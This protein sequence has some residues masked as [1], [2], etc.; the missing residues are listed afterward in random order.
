MDRARMVVGHGCWFRVVGAIGEAE[1]VSWVFRVLD[2]MDMKGDGWVGEG[3]GLKNR[4]VGGRYGVGCFKV[5][6]V[7]LGWW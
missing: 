2:R 6:C 4:L 7:D 5:P 3:D 1:M